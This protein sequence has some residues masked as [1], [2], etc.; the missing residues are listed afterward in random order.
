MATYSGVN[1]TNFVAVN[2]RGSA[3]F[4]FAV[5]AAAGTF[6]ADLGEGLDRAYVFP[7]KSG[8][9]PIS[10]TFT[11]NLPAIASTDF[12]RTSVTVSGIRIEDGLVVTV[13]GDSLKNA[14]AI[15]HP[16]VLIAAKAGN[17]S[18]GLTFSSP[19]GTTTAYQDI[20]CAYTAVR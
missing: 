11:V 9:F 8:T 10:G 3:N 6:R 18:I 1:Y 4:R 16:A 7:N 5:D 14:G 13:Q 2:L 15:Q 20:I 17:G 19:S 12:A